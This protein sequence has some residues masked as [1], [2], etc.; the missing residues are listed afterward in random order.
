V[1]IAVT[2]PVSRVQ[3]LYYRPDL[4]LSEESADME[5]LFHLMEN[6][7][8]DGFVTSAMDIEALNQQDRVIEVF[9]SSIC[10]PMAGQGAV[11]LL[12]RGSDR[13]ARTAISA[14]NDPSSFAEVELERMFLKKVCKDGRVPIGVLAKMEGETFELE[15]SI[16]ATDGSEKVSGTL[17]G[18][19]G[20]EEEVVEKLAGE[21]LASG[22]VRII[23]GTR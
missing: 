3:L 4:L 6:N 23:K 19:I 13:R 10:T 8:I 17:D 7:E 5:S 9:T 16:T 14:L 18:I 21:L 20:Q 1:R 2:D 12:I 15:A 22:G 11:G